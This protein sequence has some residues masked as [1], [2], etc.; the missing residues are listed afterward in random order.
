MTFPV[1]SKALLV[2]FEEEEI[3]YQAD[4]LLKLSLILMPIYLFVMI[5]FYFTY[6]R[7]TGMGLWV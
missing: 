1:S 2:Y 6:W 5:L 3:N 7:W 4:D